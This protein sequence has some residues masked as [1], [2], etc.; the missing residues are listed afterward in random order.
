MPT[1]AP[2]VLQIRDAKGGRDRQLPVSEPLR[3]RLADYHA[4]LLGCPDW[5]W[6]FPGRIDCR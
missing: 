2:G 4:Q 1:S 6:F 5:D 3:V